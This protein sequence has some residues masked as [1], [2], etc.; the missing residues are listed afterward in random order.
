[1]DWD[2]LKVAL[3]NYKNGKSEVDK[4]TLEEC[5]KEKR[6]ELFGAFKNHS[7]YA[8]LFKEDL[9]SDLLPHWIENCDDIDAEKKKRAVS[10]FK[11]FSTYFTGFHENRKNIYSDEAISTSV[12]YRITHDNFPKFLANIE[13]YETLKVNCPEVLVQTSEELAAYLDGVSIDEI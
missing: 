2:A 8:Y 12:T 13:V 6:K 1:L 5:Q 7:A 10:T 11:R 3:A 4:K 9:L